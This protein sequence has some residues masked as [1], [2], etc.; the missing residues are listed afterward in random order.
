MDYGTTS[1][2]PLKNIKYLLQAF[3][4][5]R[6]QAYRGSLAYIQPKTHIWSRE[7]THSFLEMTRNVM[8]FAKVTNIN[9]EV[10]YC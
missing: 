7:A 4:L 3:T 5:I 8:L 9:R 2:V 6:A 10:Y 1:N